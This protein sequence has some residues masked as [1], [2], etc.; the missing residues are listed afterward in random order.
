LA[1]AGY[2]RLTVRKD[3]SGNMKDEREDISGVILHGALRCFTEF[4]MTDEGF[5]MTDLLCVILSASIPQ[6][7]LREESLFITCGSRERYFR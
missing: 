2:P 7:K 5:R 1:A 3:E 6:R 4:S